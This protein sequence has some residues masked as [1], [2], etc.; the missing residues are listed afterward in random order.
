MLLWTYCDVNFSMSNQRLD[1]F[2]RFDIE[3]F[4]EHRIRQEMSSSIIIQTDL[5]ALARL[6]L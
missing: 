1:L 2:A 3:Y 4:K 5:I 6:F